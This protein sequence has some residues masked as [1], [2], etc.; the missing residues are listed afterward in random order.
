MEKQLLGVTLKPEKKS[1]VNVIHDAT[2]LDGE[3]TPSKCDFDSLEAEIISWE[4]HID[5][6]LK[7]LEL[8]KNIRASS[9]P[10]DP[11]DVVRLKGDGID[12]SLAK[13]SNSVTLDDVTVRGNWN[14]LYPGVDFLTTHE[15]ARLMGLS[16]KTV[17]SWI[18]NRKLLA[19]Q[20]K[21]VQGYRL[22]STQFDREGKPLNGLEEIIS[23]IGNPYLTWDFLRIPQFL[24]KEA[25][26]PIDVLESG[27]KNLIKKV[28]SIAEGF[29]SDFS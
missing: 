1:V 26:L 14:E 2:M 13:Q 10:T 22:P 15:T 16:Q 12:D 27:N 28:I 17:R 19:L 6:S 5:R 21:G 7:Y 25:V 11:S 4:I 9:R 23:I 18:K 8:L 29:G 20:R 24:D 3:V